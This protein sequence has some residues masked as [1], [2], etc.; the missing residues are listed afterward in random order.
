[1]LILDP[2]YTWTDINPAEFGLSHVELP[3]VFAGANVHIGMDH[4]NLQ[5][6]ISCCCCLRLD[7]YLMWSQMRVFGQKSGSGYLA[8]WIN[9]PRPPLYRI[10]RGMWNNEACPST[11]LEE[12]STI[13]S[14]NAMFDNA[15]FNVTYALNKIANAGFSMDRRIKIQISVTAVVALSEYCYKIKGTDSDCHYKGGDLSGCVYEEPQ[16]V[17]TLAAGQAAYQQEIVVNNGKPVYGSGNPYYRVIDQEDDIACLQK[18]A[19]NGTVQFRDLVE[20][21]SLNINNSIASEKQSPDYEPLAP[22]FFNS[23]YTHCNGM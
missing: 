4:P 11:K 2:I 9:V 15:D 19:G 14:G 3:D 7:Y 1:M 13:A 20:D 8:D 18:L 22:K 12:S 16:V 21:F 17:K 6:I 5:D 10:G 23:R